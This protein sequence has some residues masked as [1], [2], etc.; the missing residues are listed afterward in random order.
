MTGTQEFVRHARRPVSMNI[1]ATETG[2]IRR[3]PKTRN[4]EILG[5]MTQSDLTAL[6]KAENVSQ[7][8]DAQAVTRVNVSQNTGAQVVARVNVS[9]NT[10]AQVVTRVNV[11][12]NTGAQVNSSERLPEYRCRGGNSSEPLPEY[13]CTGGNSWS[14]AACTH[15]RCYRTEQLHS[16]ARDQIKNSYY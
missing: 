16:A 3:G 4:W 1:P 9:Q 12:Q 10:G 11:S 5:K 2:I 8:T 7:N 13:R 6:M 15:A 14:T